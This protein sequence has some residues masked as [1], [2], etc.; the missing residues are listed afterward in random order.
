[1]ITQCRRSIHFPVAFKCHA[2]LFFNRSDF[3]HQQRAYVIQRLGALA[4]QIQAEIH[5]IGNARE[6]M[7][8][9][10]RRYHA[11]CDDEI[12][13]FLQNGQ[14]ALIQTRQKIRHRQH[15]VFSVGSRDST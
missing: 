2:A 13:T 5:Q 12:F 15:R 11:A 10:I 14:P 3:L 9:G 1:M 8:L 4:A 6:R 7:T